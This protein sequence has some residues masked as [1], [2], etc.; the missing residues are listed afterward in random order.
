MDGS[1][2]KQNENAKQ[3][4]EK[5]KCTHGESVSW[6]KI[7]VVLIRL[8]LHQSFIDNIHCL[9]VFLLKFLPFLDH[10]LIGRKDM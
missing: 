3:T 1:I 8:E 6:G 2:T 9:N 4:E 7:S 10:C 5:K